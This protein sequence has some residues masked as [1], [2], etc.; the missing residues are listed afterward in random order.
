MS[1]VGI[2]GWVEELWCVSVG[3]VVSRLGRGVGC[4]AE[5]G[6]GGGGRGY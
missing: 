4:E 3:V 5:V 6:K 1:R 2:M